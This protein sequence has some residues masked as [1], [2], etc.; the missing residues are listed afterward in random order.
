MHKL[1]QGETVKAHQ[2][3]VSTAISGAGAAIMINA[4]C[5]YPLLPVVGI[6]AASHA[7]AVQYSARAALCCLT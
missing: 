2:E 6:G 4:C 7:L 1:T 3:H 5:A